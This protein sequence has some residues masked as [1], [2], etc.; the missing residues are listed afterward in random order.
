MPNLAISVFFL[1]VYDG[2][3]GG[4]AEI[5][6]LTGGDYLAFVLPLPILT[7]AVGGALAGQLLVED[8][9]SGYYTRLMTSS[10]HR[11]AII[12][13]PI[14]VGA[15]AVMAQVAVILAMGLLRGVDPAAGIG[16]TLVVIGISLMWGM[17]FAA[18]S[19]ALALLTRN[20]AAVQSASFVFFPFLFMAP[21]FLP[22]R[23][24]QGWLETVASYNPVTYIIEGMR[25]L[26][27]DGWDPPSIT[28]AV[29]ASVGLALVASAWAACVAVNSTARS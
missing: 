22:R 29:A 11:A 28:A 16:G 24:L 10:V 17:A 12:A 23:E 20:A 19:V 18:Y 15:V 8:I 26:L 27:I 3:L 21:A 7:A 25:S 5:N 6:Q 2:L 14:L 9:Q 13:A 1:F 4:S